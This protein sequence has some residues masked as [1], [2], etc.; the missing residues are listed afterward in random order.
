[1]KVLFLGI[2]GVL[3]SSQFIC[4]VKIHEFK[5]SNLI[6]PNTVYLLNKITSDTNASIVISSSWKENE[7]IY[8]TLY[9]AKVSA[10]IIGK[11][12]SLGN[13]DREHEIFKWLE[14]YPS[15]LHGM[16]IID[17]S[18]DMKNLIHYS[19]KTNAEVGLTY[20]EVFKAIDILNKEFN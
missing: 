5:Y 19:V 18:F 3:N 17:N 8:H 11:T 2:D 4:G 1:M 6:D 7:D 12:P 15:P 14:G 13:V 10:P 20:V 16:A 9:D